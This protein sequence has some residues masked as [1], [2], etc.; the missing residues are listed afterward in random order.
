MNQVRPKL[1]IHLHDWKHA[2]WPSVS[3]AATDL[4]HSPFSH[5]KLT[6]FGS[7][8]SCRI[9]YPSSRERDSAFRNNCFLCP[10][11]YIRVLPIDFRPRQFRFP[12]AAYRMQTLCCRILRPSFRSHKVLWA[13]VSCG[14]PNLH[15]VSRVTQWALA[16]MATSDKVCASSGTAD[17][18]PFVW[19]HF[20]RGKI[21]SN[22]SHPRA[23]RKE[24]LRRLL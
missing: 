14:P 12:P 17:E 22:D 10:D 18:S 21:L 16:F 3:N 11:R 19:T 24:H 4:A 23:Y 15:Q 9:L 5:K 13:D 2:R 1:Q 8:S 6:A 7:A 20:F